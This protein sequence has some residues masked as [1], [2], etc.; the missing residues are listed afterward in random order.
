MAKNEL[1]ETMAKHG[2]T[3]ESVFVPLSMSRN[4]NTKDERGNQ[5][6][7][8]NWKVTLCRN[9]KPILTSDYGAGMGHCPS[10]NSK[11][12]PAW[13]R[14]VRF[15]TAAICEWECEN[16]FRAEFTTWKGFVKKPA[17]RSEADIEAGRKNSYYPILPEPADVVSSLMLDAGVLD[18]G[19][20]EEWASNYGYDTD[21]R[22]AETIYR[23]CLEIALQLRAGL[24]NSIMEEL[25]EAAQ[26]Y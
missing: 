3:V 1:I 24:G 12:A 23:E 26:D 17:L 18:A 19:S 20:F 7:S 15:W 11:P 5:V 25:A 22:K 4:A 14:P 8:L 16:G 10:Y 2:I 21:S 6:H 9:G 13:N